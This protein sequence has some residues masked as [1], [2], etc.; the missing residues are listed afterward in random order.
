MISWPNDLFADSFFSNELFARGDL[1]FI[2]LAS[3]IFKRDDYTCSVCNF[4][5]QPSKDNI[6]AY[7]Q[8]RAIDNNYRNLRPANLA[9]IC[10]FCHAPFNLRASAKSGRFTAI[11]NNNGISQ[12][13]IS[14]LAKAVFAELTS[15]RNPSFEAAKAIYSE[16]NGLSNSVA[17]L[18]PKMPSQQ[19]TLMKTTG[20][21]NE[22][23]L[24]SFLMNISFLAENYNLPNVQEF[25]GK[26]CI[27]P[28][29][30]KFVD[31]ANYWHKNVYSDNRDSPLLTNLLNQL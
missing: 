30:D 18:M 8:V 23:V 20:T 26:I 22:K 31:E 17:Q 9:C 24:Q 10:A 14:I 6:S 4:S 29:F 16:F 27:F 19:L 7:F 11:V 5:C 13:E 25:L 1:K 12:K 2:E 3:S 15:N 21:S 28:L